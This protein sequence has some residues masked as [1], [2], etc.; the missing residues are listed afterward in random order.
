MAKPESNKIGQTSKNLEKVGIEQNLDDCSSNSEE[1]VNK[2]NEV[3]KLY[4]D[5]LNE[6]SSTLFCRKPN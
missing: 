2:V 1:T 3:K 4:F 6:F 5:L